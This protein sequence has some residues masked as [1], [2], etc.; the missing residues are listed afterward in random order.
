MVG[1]KMVP[2]RVLIKVIIAFVFVFPCT[3]VAAPLAEVGGVEEVR[4]VPGDLILRARLDT[5]ADHCS[6]SASDLEYFSH[7]TTEW[8][9]FSIRNR[10]G[11]ERKYEFRILRYTKIKQERGKTERRPVIRIGICLGSVFKLVDAN[12]TDRTDH[13]YPLL[14]GRDYIT[15]LMT[16]NTARAFTV[17][18]ECVLPTDKKKKRR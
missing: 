18:P 6:L 4:L 1:N 7:G 14:I 16:V 15:G 9:R 3:V 5:G 17:V 8:V 2:V 10:T 13:A 12:L 11:E